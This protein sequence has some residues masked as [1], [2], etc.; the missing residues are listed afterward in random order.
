MKAEADNTN[1][2]FDNSWY[3]TKKTDIFFKFAKFEN[4]T[5]TEAKQTSNSIWLPNICC[6]YVV[7]Y[8]FNFEFTRYGK[9]A[10]CP[11][12]IIDFILSLM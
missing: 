12:P 10:V 9:L 3:P 7:G 5:R 2:K 6:R 1:S 11:R 8:H 4:T